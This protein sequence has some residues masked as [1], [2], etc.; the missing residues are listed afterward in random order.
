[1]GTVLLWVP[2]VPA[3]EGHFQQ[4][5][6]SPP[7]LGDSHGMEPQLLSPSVILRDCHSFT[8]EKLLFIEDAGM[9]EG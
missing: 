9:F 6:F 8:K 3:L 2:G 4:C 7:T 5:L 1:M